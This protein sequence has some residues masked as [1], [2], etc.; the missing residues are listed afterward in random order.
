[1][2]WPTPENLINPSTSTEWPKWVVPHESHVVRKKAD[3]APDHVSV[4]DFEDF[5]VD[6]V[7][8][9]VTVLVKDEEDE[10]RASTELKAEEPVADLDA[11]M[12]ED[13]IDPDETVT[14]DEV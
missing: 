3:G 11:P 13:A 9:E 6:R 8:G 2:N 4:T 14:T 10:R 12:A 5:H 1:M 7:T